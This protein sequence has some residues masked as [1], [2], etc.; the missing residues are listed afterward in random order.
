[1]T[2]SAVETEIDWERI[3]RALDR[4]EL[5]TSLRELARML[6]VSPTGLRGFLDG[7]DPYVKTGEKYRRWYL[8]HGDDRP[9]M[10]LEAAFREVLRRVRPDRREAVAAYLQEVTVV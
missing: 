1:M 6:D 2:D 3:R 4:E 5:R 10:L 7:A 8:E 9:D